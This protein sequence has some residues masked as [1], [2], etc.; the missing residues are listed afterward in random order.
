MPS[1]LEFNLIRNIEFQRGLIRNA[2]VRSNVQNL[3]EVQQINKQNNSPSPN[4]LGNATVRSASPNL[5]NRF[6]DLYT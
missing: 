3:T 5:Q 4:D 2:I 6:L 1:S